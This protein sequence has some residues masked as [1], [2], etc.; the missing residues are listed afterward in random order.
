MGDVAEF[1][2]HCYE[3]A[4]L[5]CSTIKGYRTAISH[6]IKAVWR[7]D[8]VKD[9]DLSNLLANFSRD[10]TYKRSSMPAWDLALVLRMLTKEPFE[11]MHRA[12]LKHVTLKTVFLVCVGIWQK[13]Q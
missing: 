8:F 2:L 3:E 5:A 6:T 12:D 10:S 11:P 7:Q 1:M 4:H 9:A 13:V